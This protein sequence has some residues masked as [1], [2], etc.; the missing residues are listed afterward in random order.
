[1][2]FKLRRV[3]A[4]RWGFRGPFAIGSFADDREISHL[5]ASSHSVS[6]SN[7]RQKK[8][9]FQSLRLIRRVDPPGV[10]GCWQTHPTT[11]KKMYS[12]GESAE[13]QRVDVF[14]SCGHP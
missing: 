7:D 9:E 10:Q 12:G 13:M 11:G 8:T 1:M 6:H 4:F 5:E 2:A 3:L 14:L